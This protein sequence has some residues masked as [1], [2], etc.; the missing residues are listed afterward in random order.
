MKTFREVR[1]KD[2]VYYLSFSNDVITIHPI[3][4]LNMYELMGDRIVITF[5]NGVKIC[6][7]KCQLNNTTLCRNYHS[8]ITSF[9]MAYKSISQ[10]I[11]KRL[12]DV[13]YDTKPSIARQENCNSIFR[14]I[15][16]EVKTMCHTGNVK[17]VRRYMLQL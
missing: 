12:K 13:M 5:M 10:K 15:D 8:D 6:V 14:R 1:E 16:N 9:M 7:N 17:T 4:I 3:K 11:K 2:T